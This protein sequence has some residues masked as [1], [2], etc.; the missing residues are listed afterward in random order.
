M[1]PRLSLFKDFF[2][3]SKHKYLVTI[4]LNKNDNLLKYYVCKVVIDHIYNCV[5]FSIIIMESSIKFA[6]SIK[7]HFSW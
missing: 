7:C 4:F 6:V 1:E 3:Q 5:E 2:M